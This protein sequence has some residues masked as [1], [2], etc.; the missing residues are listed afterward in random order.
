MS[1]PN[2]SSYL[3]SIIIQSLSTLLET[4]RKATQLIFSFLE[5]SFKFILKHSSIASNIM[6]MLK[7]P[8][9]YDLF[10]SKL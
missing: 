5:L 2:L 4:N 9:G 6:L 7:A 3:K 10:P 1:S 8:Q